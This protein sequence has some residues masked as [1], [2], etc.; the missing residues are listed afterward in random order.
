MSFSVKNRVFSTVAAALLITA[1]G[2]S[3]GSSEDGGSS[4]T[5]GDTTVSGY[6]SVSGS[7]ATA[8][9]GISASS[10]FKA[11]D[12]VAADTTASAELVI[13]TNANGTYGD[14]GD[15]IATA[16]VTSNGSF[17]FGSVEVDTDRD[18]KAQ[19][20]VSKQGF[21]PV[22]KIITLSDGQSISVEADAASTPLLTEV[23]DISAIRA[24]G[25]MASS[26]LRLGTKRTADGLRSYSSIVSLSDMQ[27]LADVP[28]DGDVE[29]ET[30]IPLAS[31]PESVT[32]ITA[33]TQSFD[34]TNEEDAAKFPGEY[35][36][37]GEPGKGEQRL[38]SV[39]FDYMSLR[40]QNGD[41]IEL[42]AQKLSASSKLLPQAV[43]Y[44]SCLR[45]STRYL[46]GA[47]LDLFKKYGDDDN[48]TD[49]FEIPLWYYNSSAGN[50]DYLGQAE[51]YGSDGTTNYSVDST[52]TYAYAKMCITENWG[53][54]VNLDYSFAPE[55]PL[56]VCVVAQDQN[57]GAVSNLYVSAKK[58][59]ARDGH[60]LD[61]DGKTKI[62]LLAGSDV[63][64]YEFSYSGALTGWNQSTVQTS[65]ITSGGAEGCDNTINIE[66]VNPY[67]ATLKVT[68]KDLDGS[69][70]VNKYVYVY[71]SNWGEDYYSNSAY[72]DEDGIA[73]FKV[74]PNTNYG[75]YYN[76]TVVDVNINK[77]TV[78][79][80]TAD[81]GRIATVVIQEEELAPD[82]SV[83]MY[84]NS[85]SDKS[86]SV[87]FFVYASDGNGDAISLSSLK[88]NG[89]LLTE[90]TDY[91][92]TSEYSYTSYA[93]FYAKLNLSSA[94]L[95]AITPSSLSA[96][97]YSLEA[98]YSDSKASASASQRF[99]VNAN[100]AP[101]V[102]SVYLYNAAEGYVYINN[103]IKVDTYTIYAYTYDQDAD[104]LTKT[105]MLDGN[106]TGETILLTAGEHTLVVT[107]DDGAL[108]TSKTFTF[109]VGN[110]A[111]VISSF[112][113]TSYSVDLA[114][115]NTTI[116]LYA[117]AQDRDGD[118]LTVQTNDGLITLTPSYN[119]SRYF[120]SSDISITEDRT[121]TIYAND[122]EDN[123]TVQS[124]TVTTYS[125]NQAPIFDTEL[126][127]QQ[128]ASGESVSFTCQAT[129]PEGNTVSY[130][131]LVDNVEQ[132][133]TGTTFSTT[134][135]A[136][137]VVSCEATDAD[138]LEPMSATSSANITIYD[139][140]ATGTL[141]VNTLPG[142]I[143][144]IH[145][146]ITLQPVPTIPTAVADS[147][148]VATFSINGTDRT[149]FSVSVGPDVVIP[150]EV[151]FE[152]TLSEL[153]YQLDEICS[154][155][156][157]T[158]VPAACNSYDRD[159][160]I[161]GSSIPNDLGDLLLSTEGLSASD[162]DT[163]SNGSID[164]DENYT[165][166]LQESD[167][168]QDGKLTW[169]EYR[170]SSDITSEF[171]V[172]VPVREY[173]IN[174]YTYG[175]DEVAP[176]YYKD[177]QNYT[178]IVSTINFS[179]FL[180][181]VFVSIR[182]WGTT[183]DLDGNATISNANIFYG[184]ADS[185]Y[186]YSAKYIDE[187]NV[188]KYHLSLD[189]TAAD[190]ENISL[191]PSN[192]TLT[193][194]AVSFITGENQ[195]ISINS[196]YNNEYLEY[197]SNYDTRPTLLSDSRFTYKVSSSDNMYDS[198]NGVN[199]WKGN[200]NYYGDGTLKAVYDIADYPN[201]NIEVSYTED[202]TVSFS[203]SDF[204]K[205]TTARVNYYGYG[206]TQNGDA[207]VSSNVQISFNYSVVPTSMSLPVFKD[208]L[209]SMISASLPEKMYEENAYINLTEY[210]GMGETEFIN[211]VTGDD[212]ALYE[213][214]ERYMSL[215]FMLNQKLTA[216]SRVK[217]EAKPR[218]V[219]PF[220]IGFEPRALFV[221]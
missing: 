142:A 178:S 25:A 102:S 49:E 16:T 70:A 216:T 175:Y 29:T 135:T 124:L 167:T 213:A 57:G 160:F 145:D 69:L 140:S 95:S 143:V 198:V 214:G 146:S 80:E 177:E 220:S 168:D 169:H 14:D 189:K 162:L 2:C 119:G 71:N 121:F 202:G 182:G 84:N 113:A 107:A 134:F 125:A 187:N 11:T 91:T 17:D 62:A 58:D 82:V 207:S 15:K 31:L 89:T 86:E 190:I 193:G 68:V 78:S 208:I 194:T 181:S 158:T 9:S 161:S 32:S 104:A 48:T 117:Y 171:Y 127:S 51:V 195:S 149:T 105:Y 164:S 77:V 206:E 20:T 27:A 39:G 180:E 144:A 30:I 205:L 38:V 33:E 112:G 128:V 4:F 97:N 217:K 219:K 188:T 131:W 67:S 150:K 106:S 210:K 85:I 22:T 166:V 153:S 46:S 23:V 141:V 3:N 18:T 54:S 8:T 12:A 139:P 76:S 65:E 37:V 132:A 98:T 114:S 79:P 35:T 96:G 163:N 64:E 66:I 73:I 24:Q 60:Y 103:N 19:L 212:Y 221:K 63:S 36:G 56:N 13:D 133:T 179:G 92:I 115:Q 10:A 130:R 174:M 43:D 218:N 7:I 5:G 186:S 192:F 87:N 45:T 176:I 204:S 6:A 88:L 40:D 100:R 173:N 147:D 72:T 28:I 196:L 152:A 122:G 47:Q 183:T 111:P 108:T 34:P 156:A 157:D 26:F 94:T 159:T 53:T 170:G 93:Y 21:A 101:I 211:A 50:W 55:K 99:T 109:F 184:T 197:L 129:D 90:G 203:G 123:S 118:T 42:D 137:A 74:K 215:S 148:G 200:W 201:L 59:T 41:Q 120:K 116:K 151:V 61:S 185:L 83:Y 191:T 155:S 136:S 81:N 199:T 138:V 52:D 209:P 154:S 1:S 44:T 172:N 126:V 110:H 165:F 75:V